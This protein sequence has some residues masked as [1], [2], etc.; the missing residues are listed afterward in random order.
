ML[1]KMVGPFIDSKKWG[2]LSFLDIL[3]INKVA[4]S[5]DGSKLSFSDSKSFKRAAN[6]WY[7]LAGQRLLKD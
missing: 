2:H 6:M 5:F 4:F 7:N 3:E 1:E